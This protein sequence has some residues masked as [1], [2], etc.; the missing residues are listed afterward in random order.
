MA[1]TANRPVLPILSPVATIGDISVR[2]AP[3]LSSLAEPRR[4]AIAWAGV[5]GSFARGDQTDASD[6]DLL[7]GLVPRATEDDVYYAQ[8]DVLAQLDEAM[9][10]RVDCFFLRHGQPLPF[11]LCRALLHAETVHGGEAW[12]AENGARAEALFVA[13]VAKVRTLLAMMQTLLD[14]LGSKADENNATA[15]PELGT[16]APQLADGLCE[17]VHYMYTRSDDQEAMDAY[18]HGVYDR[19]LPIKRIWEE[20]SYRVPLRMNTGEGRGVHAFLVTGLLACYRDLSLTYKPFLEDII[21][22]EPRNGDDALV[23]ALLAADSIGVNA[24]DPEGCTAL[25]LAVS[26]M[27]VAVVKRLLA[28]DKVDKDRRDF[29]GQTPLLVAVMLRAPSE[30][31]RGKR[32]AIIDALLDTGMCS[33]YAADMQGNTPWNRAKAGGDRKLA[34]NMME[35]PGPKRVARLRDKE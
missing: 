1:L 17:L 34:S 11:V 24:N 32:K 15:C 27:H 26:G 35:K 20:Y 25:S 33:I 2:L 29:L 4:S 31:A 6:V 3:V 23:K 22:D 9:G 18:F 13:T 19:L 7:V 5:F 16:L 30:E 28:H 12:L 8:G 14:M 10:R 21:R